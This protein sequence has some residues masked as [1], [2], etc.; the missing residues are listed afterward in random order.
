NAGVLGFNVYDH[1]VLQWRFSDTRLWD[2]Y[3]LTFYCSL[4]I[5]FL[6]AIALLF[7]KAARLSGRGS[8]SF[9]DRIIRPHGRDAESA[10]ALGTILL[11]PVL[12]ISAALAMTYGLLPFSLSTYLTWLGLLLFYLG[13]VVTYPNH[14]ADAMTM[15]VKL[16]GVI[17]VLIL[18]T[19]G[20]VALF[21]GETSASDYPR[22]PPL[23]ERST[24]HFT[25]N[26]S[27]S[28]DISSTPDTFDPDLGPRVD[29]VY[30]RPHVEEL[31]FDFPFYAAHYRTIHILNGPM[32]YL[33]EFVRENGW[34]GYNP[35]PA[36]APLIMNLDPSRGGGI[37]FK[38]SPDSVTVTWFRL[39]ELGAENV[40]TVQLVLRVDGTIEMSFKELS[41]AYGPSTEQL[42][43]YT[44]ASTT[45]GDP[46]P[47][48]RPAPFPPRLTG[49]HP[50]GGCASGANQLHTRSPLVRPP[51][52][53]NLRVARGG[54]C[55]LPQR[56][57]RGARGAHRR[58][59][60]SRALSHPASSSS[61]PLHPPAGIVPGN[62]A[63]GGRRSRRG[64]QAAVSRRNRV[65][66]ELVQPDGGV[67]R[68][69]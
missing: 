2:I 19:M 5:Q 20:L 29:T 46:A 67:Y 24:I 31:E 45:G 58:G 22:L 52:G 50:G 14:S 26:D 33:G 42:Y 63:G 17:L 66:G 69:R 37:H 55:A 40:N 6:G 30:G 36:I 53:G 57:D 47:G 44:A 9:L 32:I 12:A 51:P 21:M 68:A 15:Q 64:G 62:A 8:R 54:L 28:Y 38:S 23:P 59:E 1:F 11:L 16:V 49:I 7:R 61:E 48:G 13:F 56:K 10:R 43:N 65:A 35:Q 3:W 39:P 60:P 4:V 18:S 25:P 34:G 27:R 41:P